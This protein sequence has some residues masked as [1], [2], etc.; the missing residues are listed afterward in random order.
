MSDPI[1]ELHRLGLRVSKEALAAMMAHATRSKMSPTQV[2][3]EL[4]ALERKEREARN[5]QNRTR[6]AALGDFKPIGE[7]D[8]NHPREIP[9]DLYE[10]LLA[11]E[12]IKPGHNVLL[13]GPSGVGKTMLAKNLG[14]QALQCG[15]KVH[16]TPLATMLAVLLRQESVPAFERKLRKYARPHLLIIDE[17]GYLPA[18]AKAADALYHVINRRH[19]LRSTVITTNLSYKQWTTVFPNAAC[20]GA[21]VDRFVQHCHAV[22]IEADSWRAKTA[23]QFKKARKV[24]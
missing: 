13:R 19:E 17:L 24:P 7:F 8:W 4:V 21:L 18:D 16:Y 1:D 6:D 10:Q 14:M 12:F 22:E 11:C 9:R 20:V 3:E 2:V 5:L 15:F 23:E